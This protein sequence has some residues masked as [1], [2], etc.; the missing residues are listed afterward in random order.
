MRITGWEPM[1]TAPKDRPILVFAEDVKYVGTES[2]PKLDPLITATM[3]NPY[4]GFT[5]C[6]VREPTCWT[7]LAEHINKM[8]SHCMA[9]EDMLELR[10]KLREYVS[11]E[12]LIKEL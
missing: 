3:Y 4:A 2:Y 11:Q 12:E 10:D 8:V 7:D 1:S 9:L 5:V 6:T